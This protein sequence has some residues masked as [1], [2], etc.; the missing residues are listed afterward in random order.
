MRPAHEWGSV[1]RFQCKKTSVLAAFVLLAGGLT[2]PAAPAV[3]AVAEQETPGSGSKLVYDLDVRA[4]DSDK[5]ELSDLRAIAGALDS[6]LRA[7][8]YGGDA[9]SGEIAIADDETSETL[10]YYAQDLFSGQRPSSRQLPGESSKL[11]RPSL[12]RS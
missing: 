9:G 11:T 4:L 1:I 12:T 10:A 6:R 5:V 3:G 8:S 7:V 2:L